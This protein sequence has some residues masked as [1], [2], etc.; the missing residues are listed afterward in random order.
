MLGPTAAPKSITEFV[1]GGLR[2]KKVDAVAPLERMAWEGQ[3]DCNG[4][5]IMTCCST[6]SLAKCRASQNIS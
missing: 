4:L 2:Q 3:A 1:D 5:H 6:I